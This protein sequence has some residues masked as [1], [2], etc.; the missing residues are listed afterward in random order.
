MS[1]EQCTVSYLKKILDN[2][3]NEGYGDMPIFLGEETPLLEDS[4]CIY[5]L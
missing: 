1:K 4:I 5:Y 2:L 3:Y